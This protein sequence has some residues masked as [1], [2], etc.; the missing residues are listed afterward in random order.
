MTTKLDQLTS[1]LKERKIT[2]VECL[3]SDLTGIA[4]GKIGGKAAGMMLAHKILQ[5]A[6]AKD[7][8]DLTLRVLHNQHISI[9]DSYFI[10]ADVFYEFHQ[11][12]DLHDFHNQK[13][14][15]HDEIV[16][17]YPQVVRR[18]PAVV[19]Q[20][21]CSLACATCWP[22]SGKPLSSCVRLACLR[23]TSAARSPANTTVFS[24]PTRAR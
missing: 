18:L 6:L 10:G 20:R 12:N 4:R 1:W 2:E 23:I 24:A 13:Y 22:R 11:L 15:S 21:G 9:P 19:F 3:I 8:V 14:K 7:N 5:H 16:A 17:E